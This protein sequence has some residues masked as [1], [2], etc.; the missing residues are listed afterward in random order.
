MNFQEN[1][2]NMIKARFPLLYLTTFEE[3]RAVNQIIYL[4]DCED[5]IKRTRNVYVW[6]MTDGYTCKGKNIEKDTKLPLKALEFAENIEEPAV[7]ILKDFHIYL[8]NGKYY[9]YVIIRKIRDLIPIIKNEE[10]PKTIIIVSPIFVLPTELQKDITLID[11]DLPK[12]ED[13][14]NIL[15]EIIEANKDSNIRI[16]LDDGEKNQI[17][18]AALGLT[19][20][21]AEN[22]FAKAIA[23]DG[24]LDI[25]DLENVLNEKSQIIKKSGV[26][27]YIQTL[28]S[29]D[30][31]GG[32]ENLKRWLKKRSKSWTPLAK[33]YNIA[34]P[35]GILITGIP[36][37]GKSLVAKSISNIWKM[38]LLRMDMGS[39]YSGILGSSEENIRRVIKTAEAISPSILWID[40]IEKGLGNSN[41]SD[42]GT[43]T[44]ILG[45]FLTWMQE[46]TAP[47]FVI[48]TANDISKLPPELL[49]KGR[50]DEIFFVDL[51]TKN[52]RK[53]IFK[54]HIKKRFKDTELDTSE[55]LDKN[56]INLFASNT[57]GFVGAEIEQVILNSVFEAFNESRNVTV[58]DIVLCIRNTVPLSVTQYEQIMNIREWAN[59]RAVAATAVEDRSLYDNEQKKNSEIDKFKQDVKMKRGGRTV[60]F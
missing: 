6:S 15:D 57:E 59:I 44:R 58:N 22:A 48:A 12:V 30:D 23:N 32:L 39:I 2:S 36:G 45:T 31:I 4:C 13:V 42:G 54:L 5:T 56:A 16:E 14:R 1:L 20:Q 37:C 17:C 9:D 26:L 21:E 11:F 43:S 19:I 50:F 10:F 46:K 27:E 28:S 3:E 24:V 49:R 25:G 47:V 52:E 18:N 60:E 33:S 51:P 53:D 38:P 8:S 7:F 29:M 34:P 41:N 55:L 40:E 35:K